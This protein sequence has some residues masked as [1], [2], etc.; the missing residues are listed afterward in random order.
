M[1][2]NQ[3]T[4]YVINTWDDHASKVGYTRLPNESN[5]SIL[6][7]LN[8]LAM[9]KENSTVQGLVNSISNVLG[10]NQ[11]NVIS[12]KIF[13]LSH[14]PEN[15][16]SV[17][18]DDVEQEEVDIDNYDD[19]T[20]GYIIWK[21]ENDK[22][23]PILEFI[24]PPEFTRRS[25]GLHNGVNIIIEYEWKDDNVVKIQTDMGNPYNPYDTRYMGVAPEEPGDVV[26]IELH[27]DDDVTDIGLI[28][29]NRVPS[30]KLKSIWKVID[31]ITPITW[32]E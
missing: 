7:R 17:M 20:S 30:E 23:T 28:D 26:I 1:A 3:K 18:V 9:Y 21:D 24:E 8:N 15:I 13:F 4:E 29:E 31:S 5:K 11:Y 32:G 6:Q 19:A 10:Y 22:Y 27:N 16:I 2:I 14:D 25:D 12:K